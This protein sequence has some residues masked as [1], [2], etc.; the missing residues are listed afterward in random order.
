MSN[1]IKKKKEEAVVEDKVQTTPVQTT[2]VQATTETSYDT[3][4]A[5]MAKEGVALEKAVQD[6]QTALATS[7]AN[8]DNAIANKTS[9]LGTIFEKYEPK[10]DENKEKRLAQR[11]AMQSLG[12]LLS[13]AV[14]GVH[15]Y[16]KRGMGYVPTLPEGSHLKSLEEI[17]RMKEEY[18]KANETWKDFEIKQ[19]IADEDAK[20]A[21][22]DALVT[23]AEADLKSA[24]DQLSKHLQNVYNL[25]VKKAD[26]VAKSLL[27]DKEQKN[28]VALETQKHQ[29]DLALE[30]VKQAKDHL[31]QEEQTVLGY[32][33]DFFGTDIYG[34]DITTTTR[35]YAKR[36]EGGS[37][38]G[39][40]ED[41][42]TTTKK[43]RKKS[44]LKKGDL[45]S[46]IR[47]KG[48][49][50]RFKVYKEFRKG[51]NTHEQALA[52]VEKYFAN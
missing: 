37:L 23:E 29:N 52:N 46:I 31:S 49:D 51:G 6:K 50:M 19:K 1:D 22:A 16:G 18:R 32:I 20:I 41:R 47:S 48:A 24:Q 33:E 10:Y 26:A 13:A 34:E 4:G 44:D 2:P 39:E 14:T 21:A 12:D 5:S 36:D 17:N 28:R 35:P 40:Y 38:T 30:A 8:R 42:T 3:L 27:E 45:Q 7:K 9:V 15:A 11:A 43:T 25:E